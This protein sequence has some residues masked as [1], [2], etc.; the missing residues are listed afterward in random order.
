MEKREETKFWDLNGYKGTLSKT[1]N[2]YRT[3]PYTSVRTIELF[4]TDFLL[5]FVQRITLRLKYNG[6]VQSLIDN[7]DLTQKINIHVLRATFLASF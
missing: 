5:I 6:L 1:I 7:F 2:L 3:H 4:C